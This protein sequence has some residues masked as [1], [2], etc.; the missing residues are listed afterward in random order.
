M[1]YIKKKIDEKLS[2]ARI[3]LTSDELEKSGYTKAAIHLALGCLRKKSQLVSHKRIPSNCESRGPSCRFP[4][5]CGV[6]GCLDQ[7]PQVW[8]VVISH[9]K[10]SV[11]SGSYR[12]QFMTKKPFPSPEFIGKRTVRSGYLSVASKELTAFDLVHFMTQSGGINNVAT[13]LVELFE[14]MKLKEFNQAA[15]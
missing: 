7:R 10:R 13:V 1:N 5:T 11:Q 6:Y 9:Q 4:S 15:S 2:S 8:Q 3:V 14:E 12:F